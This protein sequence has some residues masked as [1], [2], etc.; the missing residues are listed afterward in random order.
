MNALTV[1]MASRRMLRRISASLRGMDT[2]F[3]GKRRPRARKAKSSQQGQP[4]ATWQMRLPWRKYPRPLGQ[5]NPTSWTMRT[6]RAEE[7]RSQ[8]I[9]KPWDVVQED[10]IGLG[11]IEDGVKGEGVRER[12]FSGEFGAGHRFLEGGGEG[13]G[14]AYRDA[15]R[16]SADVPACT[17]ALR[18]IQ[19]GSF[20]ASL[21]AAEG[22]DE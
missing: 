6:V 9:G 19:H 21:Q 11:F 17:Q 10:G 15:I 13:F 12:F 1:R 7:G 22:V 4:A 8:D 3:T 14:M 18:K 16:E 2:H 5:T 20:G